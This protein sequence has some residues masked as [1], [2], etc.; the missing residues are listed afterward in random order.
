MDLLGW[1]IGCILPQHSMPYIIDGHN[2]I[3][4]LPGLDLQEIDDETKLIE[5]LQV[6]CRST[7]R[8]AEVYF[9]NAPPGFARGQSFGAVTAH[10]VR[11]GTT[12]DTAIQRRLQ[13]L[14]KAA[15]NWTVVSSD[16]QVQ[17]AA[18][19]LRAHYISA[20]AFAQ[21]LAQA[22]KDVSTGNKRNAES[23]L[24]QAEMNEW[25]ELFGGDR[26]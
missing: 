12:A 25:L 21:T 19:D 26:E 4:K 20:E 24:S 1:M 7:R 23:E 6:F 18:R 2:L 10:F 9:D 3:P 14:G 8:R 16:G 22:L 17:S 5:L 15:K 11:Q 13:R